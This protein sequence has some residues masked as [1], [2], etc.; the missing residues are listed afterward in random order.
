MILSNSTAR[1]DLDVKAVTTLG[2]T[3]GSRGNLHAAHFCYLMAQ[4]EFGTF[5]QKTSKIV[6]IGSSHTLPFQQFASNEAIFATEIFEFACSLADPDFALHHLQV[7][8]Y[9]F[10]LYN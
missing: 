10:L 5:S 3:L 4:V 1:P 8:I 2:D 7:R 6:L 9:Y